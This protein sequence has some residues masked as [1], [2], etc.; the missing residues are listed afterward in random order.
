MSLLA[1]VHLARRHNGIE[2]VRTF[3]DSYVRHDA[4]IEHELRVICKGFDGT[5]EVRSEFDR[6]GRSYDVEKISDDGFDIGAYVS[7]A[8]R[9]STEFVCFLNSHS[10]IRAPAW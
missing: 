6:A 7:S 4:G 3:V 2:P 5:V 9:V 8:T 10:E 1:V